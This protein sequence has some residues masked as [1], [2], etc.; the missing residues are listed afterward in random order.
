MKQ[1]YK[2]AMQKR[3]GYSSSQISDY[4]TS[5]FG[6]GF[7]LALAPRY[8]AIEDELK[9][10]VAIL[11]SSLEIRDL[12]IDELRKT[13]DSLV[14]ELDMKETRIENLEESLDVYRDLIRRIKELKK[15]K[16]E[17][18]EISTEISSDLEAFGD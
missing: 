5:G 7:S 13:R 11:A 8:P 18:S 6:S 16:Y 15:L 4:A 2:T 10:D 9:K 12:Y 1:F 3:N 14:T 17:K